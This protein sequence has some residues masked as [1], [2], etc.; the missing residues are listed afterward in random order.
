MVSAFF[1]INTTAVTSFTSCHFWFL[2]FQQLLQ[3]M[4]GKTFEAAGFYR[5]NQQH[6]ST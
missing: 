1:T 6:Q 2:F 3:V 5:L 4:P